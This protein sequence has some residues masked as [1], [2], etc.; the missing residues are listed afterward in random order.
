MAKNTNLKEFQN[1][2]FAYL[3]TRS[4]SAF[5]YRK[6]FLYPKID[7]FLNGKVLDVGC[8]IGDFLAYRPETIGLDVDPKAVEHCL[9]NGLDARQMPYDELPIEK[10][11]VQGVVCDNV[12]EHIADPSPLIDE[13]RRVLE[14]DGTLVVGVPGSKGYASDS[15]HKVHYTADALCE[16]LNARGFKTHHL[17]YTPIRSEFL[18]RRMRQY[19]VYGVFIN[20]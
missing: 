9:L 10:C 19:C 14:K 4:I 13:I 18:D 15:D 1:D 7:S 16:L 17:F 6:W 12:F 2:Y 8:G 3:K 11:S 20:G 5:I